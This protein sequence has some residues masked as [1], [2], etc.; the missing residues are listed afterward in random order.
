MYV[1]QYILRVKREKETGCSR[2]E[3][4]LFYQYSMAIVIL[5]SKQVMLHI[6][7]YY[8]QFK[9]VEITLTL[10]ESCMNIDWMN[11]LSKLT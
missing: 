4:S 3:K 10:F 6:D 2:V 9:Q 5:V 7:S 8:K 1:T 11:L